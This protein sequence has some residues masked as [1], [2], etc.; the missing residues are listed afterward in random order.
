[1]TIVEQSTRISGVKPNYGL[2]EYERAEIFRGIHAEFADLLLPDQT[3]VLI[4]ASDTDIANYARSVE[5]TSLPTI[6]DLMQDYEDN[7]RFLL[8]L[9]DEQD[10][11]IHDRPAHIFRVQRVDE[12][13]VF[14][15]P[16][17]LP[18]FDDALKLGLVSEEELL[19]FYQTESLHQLGGSYINVESNI[20]IDGVKRSI[21]KPYSALGYR[22]IFQLV[23]RENVRGIVA[24][25]NE[26]AIASLGHMGLIS[27]PLAGKPQLSVINEDKQII[28]PGQEPEKYFPLTLEGMPYSRLVDGVPMHNYRM[29]ADPEYAKERS[30]VAGMIASRSLNVINIL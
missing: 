29:F 1:M 18:T 13:D 7:S 12:G 2:S 20:H 11:T 8:V 17:G 26:E 15:T 21:K 10:G 14:T 19:G 24:Y 3:N 30:R 5:S 28:S 23:A 16:T 27:T 25:Q 4:A 6:P 22:A 9:Q